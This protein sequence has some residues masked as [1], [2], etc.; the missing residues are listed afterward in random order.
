VDTVNSLTLGLNWKPTNYL[1]LK[2]EIRYDNV[3]DGTPFNDGLK[4]HQLSFGLSGVLT[5]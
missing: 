2:P 1:T 5:F 4:G 3:K